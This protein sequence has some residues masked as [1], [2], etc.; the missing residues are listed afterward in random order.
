MLVET[1]HVA[2]NMAEAG[3]LGLAARSPLVCLASAPQV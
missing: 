2:A 1:H 3:R